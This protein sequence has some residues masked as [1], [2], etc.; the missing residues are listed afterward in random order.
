MS[1]KSDDQNPRYD[2]ATMKKE[3]RLRVL[4]AVAGADNR[5]ANREDE[6][7]DNSYPSAL[8]TALT[9]LAVIHATAE[10]RAVAATDDDI[11]EILGGL[12]DTAADMLG[13]LLEVNV[14]VATKD[15]RYS[16]EG[17]TPSDQKSTHA[18]ETTEAIIRRMTAEAARKD[19]DDG[20]IH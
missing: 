17:S 6:D 1:E 9:Q 3:V 8:F 10:F 7:G 16:S 11:V 2:Y 4:Q 15:A 20:S 12:A 5:Y 18:K 19:D 14:V 13:R